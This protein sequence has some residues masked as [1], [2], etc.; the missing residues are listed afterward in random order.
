M[1]A[2]VSARADARLPVWVRVVK[3]KI[4][5]DGGA[6]PRN[7]G[8]AGIGIVV[9]MNGDTHEMNRY[10]G[11]ATNNVAEMKALIVGV[12]WAAQLGASSIII[13]TDSKLVQGIVTG[14]WKCK[15]NGLRPLVAEARRVLAEHFETGGTADWEIRWVGRKDNTAADRLATAAQNFG[16]NRNPWKKKERSPSFVRD[17]FQ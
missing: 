7:P 11:K 15:N 6:G 2:L 10:I 16:R 12:K 5:T 14:A 3:A 1:P 9:R 17:P 8:H 13:Y 4:N